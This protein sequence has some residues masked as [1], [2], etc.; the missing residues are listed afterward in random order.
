MATVSESSIAL[1]PLN[2]RLYYP[3]FPISLE[4][5]ADKPRVSAFKPVA[6]RQGSLYEV[7]PRY[8]SPPHLLSPSSNNGNGHYYEQSPIAMPYDP[9]YNGG[10]HTSP[11]LEATPNAMV[12]SAL[13]GYAQKPDDNSMI[14]QQ[15]EYTMEQTQDKQ[16]IQYQQY[17]QYSY[18]N[19]LISDCVY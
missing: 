10:L 16:A 17:Q 8:Y 14:V 4:I 9:F 7:D 11:A 19:Y 6:K 13:Y 3:N 12:A 2:S 1:R 15:H 18:G 5:E